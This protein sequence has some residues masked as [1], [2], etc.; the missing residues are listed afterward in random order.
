[1]ESLQVV[2]EAGQTVG[3]IGKTAAH[4]SGGILHRA[5]S[6]FVFDEADKL[7]LQRRAATK[8]HFAEMWANSCCS[9]PLVN[10]TPMAAARRA[11]RNELRIEPS[12]SEIGTVIYSAH[13]P[14]SDLTEQ[15]YDHIFAGQWSGRVKPNPLEVNGIRWVT[16]SDLRDDLEKHPGRF[17]PWLS[18]ILHDVLVKGGDNPLVRFWA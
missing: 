18:I 14:M 13:D 17:A 9:H 5:V 2:N 15:E 16:A 6:V 10:E 7:L 8:Y 12:L 4:Q 1:M 3:T 11:T